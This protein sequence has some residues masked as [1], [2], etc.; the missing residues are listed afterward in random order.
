[1]EPVLTSALPVLR[2]RLIHFGFCNSVTPGARIRHKKVLIQP[3]GP[4]FH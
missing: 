1:M 4:N 2:S 3:V